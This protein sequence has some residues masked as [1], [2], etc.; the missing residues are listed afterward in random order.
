MVMIIQNCDCKTCNGGT[1]A[2]PG[3]FGGSTC[4]CPCHQSGHP[5]D[6]KEHHEWMM[7]EHRKHMK[8]TLRALAV[9]EGGQKAAKD[10]DE[11]YD[12]SALFPSLPEIE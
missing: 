4:I 3:H 8:E 7:S 12:D 2:P 11:N 9:A 6:S 5:V 10:F 1:P